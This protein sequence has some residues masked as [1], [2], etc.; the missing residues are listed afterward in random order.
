MVNEHLA[1]IAQPDGF[2]ALPALELTIH[3][4]LP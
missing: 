3:R 2:D 1:E 4:R